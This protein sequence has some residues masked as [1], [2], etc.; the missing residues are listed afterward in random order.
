MNVPYKHIK[1]VVELSENKKIVI[2][3][4]DKCRGVVVKDKH[5]YIEKWISLLTTKPFKQVDSDPTKTLE[6]KV[7]ISLRKLT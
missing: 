4:K 5:K 6:S 2:L 7:Q 3:K 1:I